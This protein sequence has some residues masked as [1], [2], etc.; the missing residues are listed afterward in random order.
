M[1]VKMRVAVYYNNK[2][3][4]VE[5]MPRPKIGPG[6][7]LMKV[8]ASGICGSDVLE[9]YRVPRA[10]RVLG[11]E[12]T[13]EIVEV[14]EG[15]SRY[16]VGDRV[17]VSHH[18]PCNKCHYC[19]RGHHT[20]CETLHKTNYDPGG[21]AE[22]IRVP[23]IN[24]ERGVYILPEGLPFEDGTLIEPL[25]CVVRGQRLADVQKGDCVL[26]M[27]SGV[28]GLLH[29]QLARLLG[30][31]RIIATDV[32]EYRLNAA[33]K[34]GAD[35][36]LHAKDNV[37]EELRKLN[38]GRLADKVIVC[39]GAASA[40]TQALQYVDRGGTVLYFAVPGPGFD[41]PLPA[42]E[43][44]RNEVTIMTSYGAAP[45]D[46]EES[47]KL[48]S[49]GQINVHDMIT[50]KLSLSEIGLGFRLVEEAKESLKVVIEPQRRS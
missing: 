21:F 2:D 14:G 33:R 22:Y 16:K 7:L 29:I 24:V 48:I 12:A 6:E 41:I 50:H 47:L 30:A 45:R 28:S 31:E 25:G 10:P 43:F 20:A 3:V 5:E 35:H 38:E 4:R 19:L 39:T 42:A 44:W 49:E 36:A 37:Q 18:V 17:F 40:S 9:W 34:F 15:V 13:G 23:S 32:N 8:I 1:L 26:V 11:H 27:G 46:L